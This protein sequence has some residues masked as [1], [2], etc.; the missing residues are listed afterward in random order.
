VARDLRQRVGAKAMLAG[1]IS[2][3]GNEYVIGLNAINCTTGETIVAQQA[4][5][6]GKADVLKALDSSASAMRTK[7]G[8][9]LASVEKSATP[10]REATTPS[11]EALK[12]Y[13]MGLRIHTQK[14]DAAA[15]PYLQRAVEL[16]PNFALGYRYLATWYSND[17]RSCAPAR[18]LRGAGGACLRP[19][20]THVAK[21]L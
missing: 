12:A 9:S 19:A 4:R 17:P 21:R 3:L 13:S 11:L 16:D 18:R 14:G 20:S 7:L 2:S 6:S 5:A 8:E 10:I 15:L 1:S